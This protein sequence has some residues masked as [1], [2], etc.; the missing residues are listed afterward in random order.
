MQFDDLSDAVKDR[1]HRCSN[2]G[3]GKSFWLGQA[4]GGHMRR[5]YV[6]DSIVMKEQTLKLESDPNLLN[7]RLPALTEGDCIS[8]GVKPEA[9]P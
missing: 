8:V 2:C 4:L 1:G 6:P 5:H 3:S 9:K 7:L